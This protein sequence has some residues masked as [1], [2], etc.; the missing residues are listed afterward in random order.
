MRMIW[1]VAPVHVWLRA[2]GC[3]HTR[4]GWDL[5]QVSEHISVVSKHG[6][7]CD[8]SCLRYLGPQG[9]PPK[10]RSLPAP[11]R[12]GLLPHPPHHFLRQRPANRHK[13]SRW[14]GMRMVGTCKT[15]GG[16]AHSWLGASGRSGTNTHDIWCESHSVGSCTFQGPEL[17][18]LSRPDKGQPHS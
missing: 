11:P 8:W 5:S 16:S 9:C 7:A 6:R 1:H 2:C 17:L 12:S 3:S 18:N 13:T 14:R 4:D 15:Q 10:R